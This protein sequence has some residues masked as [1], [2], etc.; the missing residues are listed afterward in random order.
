MNKSCPMADV[1][2]SEPQILKITESYIYG[3]KK[4]KLY[5]SL[6]RGIQKGGSCSI[7]PLLKLP[8]FKKIL[9][10]LQE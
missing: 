4:C 3:N 5:I 8:N 7:C 1:V 2:I 9:E 10:K 6:L